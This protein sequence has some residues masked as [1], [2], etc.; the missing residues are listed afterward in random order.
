MPRSPQWMDLYQIWFR[1]SSRGRNQLC[2]ILLQSAHRF[3]FCEG[4]KFAISHWLGRSPLTQC[5]RYRA[6]CDVGCLIWCD[7]H[8]C[9]HN[10]TGGSAADHSFTGGYIVC[11]FGKRFCLFKWGVINANCV[12]C[13]RQR[14]K[15][16]H[17]SALNTFSFSAGKTFYWFLHCEC[18]IDF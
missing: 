9:I 11:Q 17:V 8:V 7:W 2:G 6:A 4:S 3:R 13:C 16:L 15:I 14:Q 12:L 1:V 18:R 5:W 10:V